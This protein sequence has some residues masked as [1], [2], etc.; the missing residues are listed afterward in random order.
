MRSCC[1]E[2]FWQVYPQLCIGSK[3]DSNFSSYSP[4]TS[5]LEVKK[6][7]IIYSSMIEPVGV[8]I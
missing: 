6:S 7:F 8:E 2:M 3:R 4:T 1:I 5:S